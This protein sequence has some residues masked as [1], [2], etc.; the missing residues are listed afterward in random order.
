MKHL[1]VGSVTVLLLL[2]FPVYGQV[3]DQSIIT[4]AAQ[5]RDKALQ[6]DLALN[7]TESLTTEVGPRLA[8][9]EADALA[10][11]WAMNTLKTMGFDRVWKEP[12]QIP[13]WRRL[14]EHAEV[15]A[16]FPQPLVVTALGFSVSTPKQGLTA[17]IMHFASYEAMQQADDGAAKN[18]IIYVSNKMEKHPS[19]R[20]YGKAGPARFSGA[21]EAARLGAVALVIRSIGT[22]SQRSPHTGVTT[23]SDDYPKIPAA[24]LSNPDADQLDRML[25]RNENI[26]LHLNIQTEYLGQATTY[27]VIGEI[28]G[29]ERPQEIVAVGGHL[30]SWDLGTGAVDDAAGIGITMA[31]AKLIA[32]QQRPKRSIRVVLFGA[33]EIGVYGGKQYALDHK[34]ELENHIIG[35]ESDGGAGKVLALSSSVQPSAL[36]VVDEILKLMAP[37]NIVRS[38]AV[39]TGSADFGPMVE[40]G[41]PAVGLVQD[42]TAYFD[43]HHTPDDTFDKIDPQELAQ[44]LAAWVVF[45]K[46]AADWPGRF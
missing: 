27:N 40:A 17:P 31:A 8:G 4:Q 28:T 2:V 29:S 9:S 22:D 30:D 18:K 24:A 38:S 45:V 19:G 41:M 16:P 46:I 33:E 42:Y 25:R 37:L 43:I 34:D 35:A 44:N 12:V 36:H 5:L 10:V 14:S 13:V 6:S 11:E 26:K 3:V 39:A 21:A 1:L 20:G 23:Y 15:M 32:E 7:I